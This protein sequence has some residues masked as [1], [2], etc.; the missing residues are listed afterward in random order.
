MVE[1]GWINSIFPIPW[2]IEPVDSGVWTSQ[3]YSLN[4]GVK[5]T[6]IITDSCLQSQLNNFV[7]FCAAT[8]MIYVH[9]CLIIHC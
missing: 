3:N 4:F 2:L 1:L 6:S 9:I 8:T 5:S 7:L